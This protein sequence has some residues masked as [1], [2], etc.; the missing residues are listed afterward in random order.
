MQFT[1]PWRQCSRKA[2]FRYAAS[3]LR[4]NGNIWIP[5]DAGDACPASFRRPVA[6]I[7][8]DFAIVRA[9]DTLGPVDYS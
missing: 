9:D 7:W 8:A 2:T 3:E 4:A 5:R 1:G 6:P